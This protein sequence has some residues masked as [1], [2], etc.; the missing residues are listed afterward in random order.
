MIVVV[1]RKPA[2]FFGVSAASPTE[3]WAVGDVGTIYQFNGTAWQKV[4]SG[5]GSALRA[6]WAAGPGDAW[7]VGDSIVETDETFQLKLSNPS[8]ATI[9]IT[10]A[11]RSFRVGSSI[12]MRKR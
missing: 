6:V 4:V 5:T 8:G 3:A 9:S 11:E 1:V 10:R 2:I 12:S 7:A